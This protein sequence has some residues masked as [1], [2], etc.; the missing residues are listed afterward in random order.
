M[1][2]AVAGSTAKTGATHTVPQVIALSAWS[3]Q[4]G[5]SGWSG[6]S[7]PPDIVISTCLM[8]AWTDDKLNPSVTNVARRITK[9]RRA[10][11]NFMAIDHAAEWSRLQD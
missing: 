11:E 10:N 9:S 7:I 8:L 6:M 4:F 5:Q 2:S 1:L 3:L